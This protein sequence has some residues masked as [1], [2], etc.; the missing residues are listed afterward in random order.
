MGEHLQVE[1]GSRTIAVEVR[2]RRRSTLEIAVEPDA[3]IV[4]TAP[5]GAPLDTIAAKIRKRA[6]WILRQQRFFEQF[7]PRRTVRRYVSGETHL[8][9]GRQY[10]LRIRASQD[11]AVTL[12]NGVLLVRST[13]PKVTHR[14]R[15]LVQRWYRERAAQRFRERLTVCLGRFANSNSFRP[16]AV[17]VRG[18][19]RRWGSMS[20]SGRL[21]LNTMLIEAPVDA[22][23][24][25]IA[26][27]LCHRA[28]PHHGARFFDLLEKVMPDWERRKRRLERALA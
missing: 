9:L 21:M 6:P 22:I 16:D 20:P 23:D 27:E 14:I 2:R 3:R 25:V 28:E 8:Y 5:I 19:K 4:A 10:R 26:H 12:S 24:Y 11:N 18:M 7:L 17:V 1:Y 15:S 13:T